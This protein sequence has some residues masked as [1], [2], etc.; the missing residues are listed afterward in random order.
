MEDQA[1]QGSASEAE[2]PLGELTLTAVE[3]RV[4]GCMVEKEATTPDVYPMTVNALV[5]AANQ[6]TSR[7]PVMNLTPG[8]VGHALRQ[9]DRRALVKQNFGSRADRW[10]HRFAEKFGVTTQQQA[11]L[12]LLL[13]RGAQTAGELLARSE[14]LAKFADAGD[15]RHALDRLAEREP[16]LV[17]RIPRGAGQREDR[18]MQQ[19]T[20]PVDLSSL[21]PPAA[22]RERESGSSGLL[23]RIEA[24]EARMAELEAALEQRTGGG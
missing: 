21:P 3:A 16:P 23:E 13:L 22:G 7:D 9:L 4:L 14:R 5:V 19:L 2:R 15:L 11:L 10:E 12:A 18:W 8:E 17:V 24:L 20:G 1:Q 6:K